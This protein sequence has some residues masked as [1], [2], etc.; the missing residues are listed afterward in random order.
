MDLTSVKP[1]NTKSEE[2]SE[3]ASSTTPTAKEARLMRPENVR[4]PPAPKK[5]RPSKAAY[6]NGIGFPLVVSLEKTFNNC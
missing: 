5:S 1:I 3:E 6:I 4:C 2:K